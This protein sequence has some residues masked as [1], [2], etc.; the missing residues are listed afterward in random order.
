MTSLIDLNISGSTL[1]YS[2]FACSYYNKWVIVLKHS[3][4]T[5]ISK[6]QEIRPDMTPLV[7]DQSRQ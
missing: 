7:P 2:C 3:I 1:F 6:D 4:L 5:F